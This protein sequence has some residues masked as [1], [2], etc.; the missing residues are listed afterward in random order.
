MSA[1]DAR[2]REREWR[3]SVVIVHAMGPCATTFD[4]G[5][6]VTQ[7]VPASDGSSV[8]SATLIARASH[9]ARVEFHD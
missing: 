5:A 2:D 6:D 3:L 4:T 7:A 8:A 1:E 9:D